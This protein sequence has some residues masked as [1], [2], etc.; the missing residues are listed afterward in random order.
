MS[1]AT[2][3][4]KVIYISGATRSGSTI[5]TQMLGELDDSFAPGE[6]RLIWERSFLRNDLCG[7]GEPFRSCPTWQQVVNDAFDGPDGVDPCAMIAHQPRLRHLPL[8]LMGGDS[9]RVQRAFGPYLTMLDRF[10]R[11]IGEVTQS[12]VIVD[13]SKSPMYGFLLNLLPSVDLYVVHLVRDP[14]GVQYSRMRRRQRGALNG[15]RAGIA[16]SALMW[17]LRNGVQEIL[18]RRSG[19]PYLRIR[20]ED[21]IA[22]PLQTIEAI[23]TF[24]T[25]PTIGLPEIG[26]GEIRLR[27]NHSIAGSDTRA[28]IGVVR[29][30]VDAAWRTGLERRRRVLVTALTYPFL[31]RYGY[32]R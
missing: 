9:A 12:R 18:T 11:S 32:S 26:D 30:R 17:N 28:D 14:R 4:V 16:V 27:P 22:S 13:S 21:L 25:E 1:A 15:R 6:L 3:S 7:C 20:Y 31:R 8:M 29:L 10:Y 5:L 19:Q 2:P 23:K 24:I